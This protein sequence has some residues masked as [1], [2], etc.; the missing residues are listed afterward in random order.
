MP[1]I[2]AAVNAKKRHKKILKQAKGYW[3]ARS[4][5]VRVAK[6]AVMKALDNAFSGRKQKKREYRSLW[7]V[8]INAATREADMSYSKFMHGLKLAGIE[9][10]RKVLADMAVNDEQGLKQLIET[11]K[12]QL[13]K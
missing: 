10:N 12:K 13:T 9:I 4:K 11:S 5:Q 3:G 7:I 8:R 1:R 2:K 6:E